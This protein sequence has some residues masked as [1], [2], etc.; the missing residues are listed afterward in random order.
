MPK[1]LPKFL[2][3]ALWSYDLRKFNPD[4]PNDQRLIIENILNRGTD[5]QTRW[6]L[7]NLPM[8]LIKEVLSQ[9][10]RGFW[11]RE[12]LNYWTQIFNV[13]IDKTAYE[14]AIQ[15]INPQA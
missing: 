15:N 9:P 6:L 12:S 2:Q 14:Q 3:S 13:Y 4:D 8:N 5:E 7:Q 10:V 11:W 1:K